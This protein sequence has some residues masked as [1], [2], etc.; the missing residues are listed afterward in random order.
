MT[1][2]KLSDCDKNADGH[3]VAEDNNGRQ[4]LIVYVFNSPVV[5]KLLGVIPSH[6]D[7]LAYTQDGICSE[8]EHGGGSDLR[9][10]AKLEV[11]YA[12][13]YNNNKNAIGDDWWL[14]IDQAKNARL[15]IREHVGI[16]RLTTNLTTGEKK[17]EVVSE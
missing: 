9:V 6:P 15:G 8:S 5:Y 1:T 16:I 17:L 4:V 10:P 14:S 11:K 13:V 3:W 12:N 2:F 7:T